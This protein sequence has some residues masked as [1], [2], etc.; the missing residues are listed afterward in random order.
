M[1]KRV[2]EVIKVYRAAYRN[3]PWVLAQLV[4]KGRAR[5]VMR[6]GRVVEGDSHLIGTI[7]RLYSL[8][9]GDRVVKEFLNYWQSHLEG[10]R[11]SDPRAVRELLSFRKL[12]ELKYKLRCCRLVE[13]SDDL[14]HIVID[15]GGRRVVMH[16]WRGIPPGEY[17]DY[18]NILDVKGRSVLD[19]GAFVGDTAILFAAMGARRVVAV[20]PSPWAYSVA[21]K[22]VEVNGLSDIIELV[23]CAVAR[24]GGRVLMLPSGETTIGFQATAVLAGDVPVPTCTLDSL[25]EKY[26]PFDVL[27]MD[28]EGCEHE[29]IPYSRRIGEVKEVL[30]E[31]HDGYE[32]IVR[33][34]REE[35]FKNMKFSSIGEGWRLRDKP[36]DAK[37]GYIYASKNSV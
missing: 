5:A 1:L 17:E 20:E 6:S 8:G 22:N 28:C 36:I 7:A 11:E 14:S 30:I 35:G 29:S 19:I 3:W 21:R 13:V 24:E 23:N 4:L 25:I 31:Y 34:L 32:D 10:S 12:Y 37:Q 2:G 16:G 26:G 9:L 27:K 33:K 15:V 18:L